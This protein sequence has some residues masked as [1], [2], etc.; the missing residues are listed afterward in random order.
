MAAFIAPDQKLLVVETNN[1]QFGSPSSEVKITLNLDESVVGTTPNATVSAVGPFSTSLLNENTSKPTVVITLTG[2]ITDYV[3]GQRYT[4]TITANGNTDTLAVIF[5]FTQTYDPSAWNNSDREDTVGNFFTLNQIPEGKQ[6]LSTLINSKLKTLFEYI[7]LVN[8]RITDIFNKYKL[9]K[10]L[11]DI[12]NTAIYTGAVPQASNATV[13]YLAGTTLPETII[14]RDTNNDS[15][16]Y[17]KISFSYATQ[18][19]T[20]VYNSVSTNSNY[21]AL[22]SITVDRVT[23]STGTTKKYR[24]A[25]IAIT[26]ANITFPSVVD[27]SYSVTMPLVTGWTVT[28]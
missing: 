6:I 13:T 25:S 1:L 20:I 28:E 14:I 12:I 15:D 2:A 21:S 3:L 18:V 27:P 10:N 9:K 5:L 4:I 7:A 16:S 23:D 22:D 8:F 26:R 19:K 24:I 17:T 11:P